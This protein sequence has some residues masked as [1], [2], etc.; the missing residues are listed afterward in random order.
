MKFND[1]QF[2]KSA[3]KEKIAKAF[4]RFV[5]GGFKRTQFTKDLYKHLSLHFGFIA[6]YNIDGFYSNRFED[7]QGRVKTF[8]SILNASPWTFNDDNTSGTAD[9]NKY[10]QDTVDAHFTSMVADAKKQYAAQLKSRISNLQ[11]ELT[12]LEQA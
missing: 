6:H 9:L 4:D 12:N 8:Q 5:K 1:G 2:L 7:L 3:D 11:S 10:I